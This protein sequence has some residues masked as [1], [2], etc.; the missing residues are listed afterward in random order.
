VRWGD[1]T[2]KQRRGGQRDGAV[3]TGYEIILAEN[4]P[5]VNGTTVDLRR[6]HLTGR[7]CNALSQQVGYC[8][9]GPILSI[10][11]PVSIEQGALYLHWSHPACAQDLTDSASKFAEPLTLGQFC[12]T[13]SSY[14][15]FVA[16]PMWG[17]RWGAACCRSLASDGNADVGR[18]L[19]LVRQA[20][21]IATFRASHGPA[22]PPDAHSARVFQRIASMFEAS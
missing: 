15:S 13:L 12:G 1:P 19:L 22:M 10:S 6:V 20:T 14:N 18:E 16:L 5:P 17:T 7:G 9:I 2:R 8:V 4:S 3:V 11:V 21:P